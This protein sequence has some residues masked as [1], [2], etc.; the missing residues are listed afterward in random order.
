MRDNRGR[1]GGGPAGRGGAGRVLGLALAVGLLAL[2]GCP[3][4]GG[5]GANGGSGGGLGSVF[6]GGSGKF[7]GQSLT[8]LSG[9]ENQT[10]APLIDQ[11][12]Q[13]NGCT[14]KLDYKGSVDIMLALGQGQGL[15]EDA[16]WPA[17]SMWITLGDTTKAVKHAE[18]M[19]RSPVVL[20]V[21][22]SVAQGL[23]WVGKDVHVQ[24]ILD[25]AEQGKLRYCMTSATQSNSGA[26]AY[27]GYL[28]AFSGEP[29]VLTS[30]DLQKPELRDKIKRILGTVNRSSGSS[31]WL[32][33]F[34]L[35][36]YDDFDALVDYEALIIEANQALVKQGREPLYAVYPV[37]GLAIADSPLGY[38]DKGDPQ[39]E[40]LFLAL[41][42]YLKSD[43][44]QQRLLQ[45]GRRTA[46][47]GM[48]PGQADT[49][50]FNPD[51]GIDLN[52]TIQ[53]I[54]FPDESVLRQA[55][56]LY[57][58]AFRKPSFTVYAL[59]FSGSM[60][61]DG[62]EGLKRAMR[63]LLEPQLAAKYFLQPTA[64]DVTVVVPFNDHVLGTW[65]VKGN[66]PAQLKA[67]MAKIDALQPDGNTD[68]YDPVIAGLAQFKKLGQE[69]SFPAVILM[70]D[71]QSNTGSFDELQAKWQEMGL[72]K[73]I[74]IFSI[75]FGEADESQL[76][77]LADYSSGKIFDG[78]Q[79]LS[80]AFRDAKGFN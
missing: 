74:P 41:Q 79:D 1:P 33:D 73:N 65:V 69:R 70:T 6:G 49:S 51:W 56:E 75:T 52:R 31:G 32:K 19:F 48:N 76:Q 58:T 34:F 54:R 18:S 37:D 55:L 29:D 30:A 64:D 3:K 71:G 39:K 11:F 72:P 27:F 5:G 42:A 14:I 4:P 67:L 38:I 8:I 43:A 50:V 60:E 20:G 44:V 15:P 13:Q 17:N 78:K 10:L 40:Q 21:K 57:Q 22:K 36:Q 46:T 66:D 68:I 7:K 59:D 9:S 47:V 16:V 63:S 45:A 28:Y 26:S 35:K 62:A 23:G 12:S 53:P 24:D 25:A 80:Q 77:A 2:A 61:G